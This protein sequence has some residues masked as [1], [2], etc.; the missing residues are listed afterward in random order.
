[1]RLLSVSGGRALA[2]FLFV[3]S[4]YVEDST[5]RRWASTIRI[6]VTWSCFGED[7]FKG[8]KVVVLL[9]ALVLALVMTLFVGPRDPYVTSETHLKASTRCEQTFNTD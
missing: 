4:E 1:M 5:G 6:V 3:L 7:F 2:E 8:L 9:V